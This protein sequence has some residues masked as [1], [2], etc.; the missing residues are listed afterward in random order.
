MFLLSFSKVVTNILK[1]YKLTKI[2]KILKKLFTIIIW[3]LNFIE[4]VHL[5]AN[6]SCGTKFKKI[7]VRISFFKNVVLKESFFFV[8]SDVVPILYSK[9]CICT[10]D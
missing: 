1:I 8:V 2:Y 5:G 3:L 9:A 7:L 10:R 4:Y 6:D